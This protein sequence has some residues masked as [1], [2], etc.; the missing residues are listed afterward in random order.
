M[1]VFFLSA[2]LLFAA[3]PAFCSEF[4]LGKEIDEKYDR[5]ISDMYRLEFDKAEAEFKEVIRISSGDP[6]GY[7]AL[8]ALSWWRYSQNFDIQS[9]F[10]AIEEEFMANIDATIRAAREKID[11]NSSP[12]LAYFFLGSAYGLQGRW[13]AV[14]R[15][16]IK[17]YWQGSKGRKYL[18]RCVG[19]NPEIYDA[20][21]GLGIFDYFADTLPGVLK[22]PAL[23]FVKGDKT[24]GLRQVRLAMKKGRF[25]SV[26]ARL[27][28]IEILTRHEK[29]Y[30]QAVLEVKALRSLDPENAFFWLGEILTRIHISDWE[31]ALIE[32]EKFLALHSTGTTGGVFQQLSLVYLSAGDACLALNR[33]EDAVKCFDA[34]IN[35]TSFPAKGWVTYCHLRRGQAFDL[36]EKRSMAE[37]DYLS[38]LS[39]DNF[40][41]SRK[42]AKA[43]LK[44]PPDREEV[45]R[46]LTET[47]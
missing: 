34:G 42:Y 30:K 14:Q 3:G 47:D 11:S 24:G 21:L 18:R 45:M 1:R 7:F 40:W 8:S 23:L 25:F 27:F 37:K 22:L 13:Y 41:D 9:D 17:A 31:G 5:G 44:T 19:L 15:R 43:A 38:V 35:R 16:W 10:Q 32:S 28:L 12:D 4:S 26:E 20:Y 29:D 6:A 36:M 46:Q 2:G 33:L 39:R